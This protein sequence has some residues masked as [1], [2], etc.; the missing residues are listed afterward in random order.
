MSMRVMQLF[1]AFG[2]GSVLALAAGAAS[3]GYSDAAQQESAQRATLSGAVERVDIGAG[4]IWID[5]RAYALSGIAR[6]QYEFEGKSLPLAELQPGTAVLLHFAAGSQAS[7]SVVRIQ[8]FRP[9]L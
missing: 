8:A 6:S 2:A 7:G 5:S 1:I 3:A 4:T 9:T